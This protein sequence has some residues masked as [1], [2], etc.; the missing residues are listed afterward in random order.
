M[1][2]RLSKPHID[3]K[4]INAVVEV[5]KS[6]TLSLGPKL[7]EFKER[8]ANYIGTKHAVA[9]NSG[10]SGLHLII[11][12]LGIR[13]GDEVITTPF[14]F[15]A[16]ANCIL[17]EGGRI[18]FADIDKRTYNIDPKA[19]EKAITKRTKA[20]LVVHVFGQTA[21]MTAIMKIAK[22]YNLKVIE[23]ACEAIGAMHKGK[24]AGT[25]GDAAVFAF[26]PN[27]QMTT[28]EGGIVVTHHEERAALMKS[29]KNQGRDTMAWLGHSRIGYNYRLDEMS[30]ALGITQLKK[31]GKLLAMRA[32][33]A[34]YYQK[35]LT[36]NPD[37]ILPFVEKGNE[38]SWF[39]FVI[40]LRNGINRDGVIAYLKDKGVMS[41]IYFPAIHLQP[42]YK[43]ELG[44]KEGDFPITE[45][46]SKQ[47][48]ALPFFSELTKKE[49]DYV[50]KML[51]EAIAHNQGK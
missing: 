43:K 49:V 22:K 11:K 34:G 30:C 38:A 47:T 37:I 36:N 6:G 15:V 3:E 28:G 45:A 27:K 7:E 10:T 48:I 14:S 16:S 23:D 5:L 42:F 17:F 18:V 19:I 31:I 26:Y 44:F 24:K 32:K 13:P 33:V 21:N 35:K 9:V 8:F 51:T 2:I 39:V 1:H 20:I 46:I 4:D 40:R 29:Y 12:S 50:C 41:N 25:F